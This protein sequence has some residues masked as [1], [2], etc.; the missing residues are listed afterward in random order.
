MLK[1]SGKLKVLIVDDSKVAIKAISG[2][3]EDIGVHPMVA[4]S[5][6]AAIEV[7]QKQ[8]PDIILLDIILP[9]INGYEVARQVRKLQ[10]RDDWTAII[11]LS[12]MA[13]DDDLAR[14]IEAGGDDYLMKPVGRVVLQA[15][16]SAM[17][18]LVRMQ[19][20][21]VQLTGQ[22]NLANDQLNKANLELHRVSMT[23][24]LTGIANR[25]LLD[26]SLAREWRRCAR[27]HKPI[28]IVMLDVD[29]FK[30]YNDR[31]GHQAGDECLKAIASTIASSV[32]RASDLAARY[33]GEEFV[34]ILG[35][36]DESGARLVANR[37]NQQVARLKIVNEGSPHYFVTVSCGISTVLPSDDKSVEHL[38]KSADNAL[39]LAK[40]QGRNTLA[41]LDYG[42]GE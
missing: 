1:K 30:K 35:E 39:Y 41:Y 38:I 13:K 14:G 22:L 33:G 21:L 42:Q 18:R 8:R 15:K 36:T 27:I 28:S 3:L 34:L 23:D 16:V 7:Y 10:G 9:D 2:F 11:F 5:G 32:P 24:G 31:Y 25:R 40:K 26:E 6:S 29:L 20:A 17:Y 19:R 37:L 12:V 4:D